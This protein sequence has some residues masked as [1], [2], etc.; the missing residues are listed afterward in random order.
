MS[1]RFI[2]REGAYKLPPIFDEAVDA[3]VLSCIQRRVC[4]CPDAAACKRFTYFVLIGVI[5]ANYIVPHCV[6]CGLFNP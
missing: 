1:T 4:K 6:N 5:L 3:Y 2:A